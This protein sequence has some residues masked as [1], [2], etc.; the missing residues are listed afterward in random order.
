MAV[1]KQNNKWGFID[2]TGKWAILPVFDDV[3][4][5]SEGLAKVKY[6]GKIGFIALRTSGE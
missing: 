4:A 6:N 5:F 2:K 3:W 1:A